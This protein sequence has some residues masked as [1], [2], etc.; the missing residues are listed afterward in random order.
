LHNVDRWRVILYFCQLDESSFSAAFSVKLQGKIV[1]RDWNVALAAGGSRRAIARAF[2]I[3]RAQRVTLE[4]CP[5]VDSA[6]I[7]IISGLEI[8]AE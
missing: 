4:L 6:A 1:L 8:V 2:A 5:D 3:D 7:P